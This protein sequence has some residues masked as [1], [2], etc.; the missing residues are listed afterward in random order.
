MAILTGL[1]KKCMKCG[2]YH[3]TDKEKCP[4]CGRGLMFCS[5]VYQ[6]QAGEKHERVS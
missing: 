3:G 5:I 6:P 1:R 4:E 2:T